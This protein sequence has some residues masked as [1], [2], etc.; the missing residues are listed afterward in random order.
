MQ[1]TG[2]KKPVK[3]R[4]T[5][6]KANFLTL[7]ALSVHSALGAIC[8]SPFHRNAT[9]SVGTHVRPSGCSLSTQ[10]TLPAAIGLCQRNPKGK[11]S[12]LLFLH[13]LLHCPYKAPFQPLVLQSSPML[14]PASSFMISSQLNAHIQVCERLFVRSVWSHCPPLNRAGSLFSHSTPSSIC[15]PI[16]ELL[17]GRRDPRL[18]SRK[19]PQIFRSF[20]QQMVW[21]LFRMT[22]LRPRMLGIFALAPLEEILS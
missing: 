1:P 10:V 3:L 20:H 4:S 5:G 11:H 8:A 14:F 16:S 21:L 2:S 15:I 12:P 22:S 6:Q 9:F 17:R 13:S 18:T 7:F 19:S